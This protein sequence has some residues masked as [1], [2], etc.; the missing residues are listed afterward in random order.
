M[1]LVMGK[2]WRRARQHSDGKW[3]IHEK[4]CIRVG[5]VDWVVIAG[6]FDEKPDKGSLN[7]YR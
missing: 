4:Q 6:P 2:K 3:Y 1:T 5:K 7:E